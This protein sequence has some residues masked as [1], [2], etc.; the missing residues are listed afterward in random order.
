[1]RKKEFNNINIAIASSKHSQRAYLRLA[2]EANGLSVII[3]DCLSREFIDK[4]H[5][6]NVDV[7][8]LDM[9]D[10]DDNDLLIDE[11]VEEVDIPILFNDVTALTLNEPAVLAKWYGKLMRKI[12][13]L[14]GRGITDKTQFDRSYESLV[15]EIPEEFLNK[16]P[17]DL[18]RNVW[19]IGSSLGGPEAVKRFLRHLPEDLPWPLSWRNTWGQILSVC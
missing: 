6:L 15:S 1:M 18:A 9:H 16:L 5:R 11:L 3:N 8:L 4:V 10:E 7:M 14:T 2:M 17:G 19:V 13:A 12:A